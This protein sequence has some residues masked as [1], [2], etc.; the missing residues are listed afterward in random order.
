MGDKRDIDCERDAESGR[1]TERRSEG[2]MN[3]NFKAF[4]IR[5]SLGERL[6]ETLS[7]T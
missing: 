6:R 5:L 7:E 3:S 1:E 2:Q 4:I